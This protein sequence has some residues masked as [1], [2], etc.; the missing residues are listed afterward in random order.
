MIEKIVNLAFSEQ[1]KDV[2]DI[3]FKNVN[4]DHI[5]ADIEI[6]FKKGNDNQKGGQVKIYFDSQELS[7]M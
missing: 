4:D 5:K 7:I 3:H 1:E 2:D 6:K